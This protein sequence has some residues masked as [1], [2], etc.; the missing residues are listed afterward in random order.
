MIKFKKILCPVDYSDCSAKALRYA[1]GLALKD[2]AKLYLMHV[3]DKRVYDY[4]GPVYEAQLSPDAEV[5]EH[6]KEKLGESVPKE[7]RG[8]IDVETIVTVGVPAQEIVNAADDKEVD[9]I[10]MGTH[11]RTG[12]AHVVMGSVAENVVR[13]ALCPVLTV[14]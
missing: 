13:K 6:L 3:I 5:I 10:V 9:V 1:A 7:I 14:R 8:D 11:G 2:S 4:G 12:I